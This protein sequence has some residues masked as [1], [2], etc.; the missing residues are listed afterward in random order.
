MYVTKI[1]KMEIDY[2]KTNATNIC[3]WIKKAKKML[4]YIYIIFYKNNPQYGQI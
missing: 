4:K 2:I 1:I 3:L